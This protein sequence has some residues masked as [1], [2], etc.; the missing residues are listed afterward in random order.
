M[1][2]ALE[3]VTKRYADHAVVRDVSL[4]IASGELCVL[5]GPSGSGKST[6][7][8][9]IA[10][11]TD[12]DAGR[13]LLKG[14]DVTRLSPQKR[15]LG[16]V[17]QHYALFRH[18]TVSENVE[19]ALRIRGAARSARARRRDALLEMVGLAGL[20][21]RKPWQLSGGQQQRVALARALAHEP[22]VLLLD[23]PFGALDARIRAELRRTVREIHRELSV[24]TVFVTHDQDE[25][26]ELADRLAVVD[27][28]RVLETGSP[29][30]VYL[31]PRTEFT[32]TFLGGANLLV[33]QVGPRGVR[34]G[35]LEI[36]VGSS[37]AA[38]GDS[39][40][41][42]VL[43]RPE[44]VAVKNA[45]EAQRWPS[46]GEGTVVSRSFLGPIERLR[47][48]LPLPGVRSLAPVV[49]FGEDAVLVDAVRSQHQARRF[50]LGPGDAAWVGL[51]RVHTIAHPG[52][53]FLAADD[54]PETGRRAVA[55]GTALAR[56]ARSHVVVVRCGERAED[57]GPLDDGELRRIRKDLPDA[58]A[59]E[60]E[61][62]RPDLVIVG[63][64][65]G[66]AREV[67][68]SLL[69]EGGHHLLL[70]PPGS[71]TPARILICSA[72]G[73]PGKGGI[74]F[75]GRLARHLGASATVMTVVRPDE[76]ATREQVE[77]HLAACVRTLQ[78]L[79][80]PATTLL[81]E[82]DPSAE[83][84]A[85]A[86][87]G[88]HDLIVAGSPQGGSSADF[89][90]D[91]PVATLLRDLPAPLLIVRYREMEV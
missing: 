26:F 22:E 79:G 86:A 5:L 74:R 51:R 40:R 2:I 11:L 58:V 70:L 15:G 60:A 14:K 62:T 64:G 18:M 24:T 49:P 20:G 13:V 30:E 10:G 81:R 43:F 77:R 7:L 83:I 78:P 19:F 54:G 46:L 75:S 84:F 38:V 39:E 3:H 9:I 16:F 67:A 6:I 41:V 71:K 50:P 73:E 1:S 4:E 28:G 52:L 27:H 17:F 56:A 63:V 23:E 21:G 29:R 66:D 36:P 80:V 45:D 8:R 32:A 69:A 55:M 89:E 88:R 48:R 34:L 85:E 44:D 76:T 91:G 53:G 31:H 33:G 68:A 61:R 57:E 59:L 25:A 65:E 82:G 37:A 12:P 47:I 42:Q 35:E 87:S 90:G 72:A